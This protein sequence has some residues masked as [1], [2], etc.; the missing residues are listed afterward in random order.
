MPTDYWTRLTQLNQMARGEIES[1]THWLLAPDLSQTAALPVWE[2][3]TVACQDVLNLLPLPDYAVR[4][5][6]G[7]QRGASSWLWHQHFGALQPPN[8]LPSQLPDFAQQF[9]WS[10]AHQITWECAWTF[11]QTTETLQSVT[12][13]LSYAPYSLQKIPLM[14][15]DVTQG[16]LRW[17][18]IPANQTPSGLDDLRWEH[19]DQHGWFSDLFLTFCADWLT[20]YPDALMNRATQR[21]IRR[22][23][24]WIQTWG[25]TRH[26][27][28]WLSP[29]GAVSLGGELGLLALTGLIPSHG[30]ATIALLWSV[31]N[32]AGWYVLNNAIPLRPPHP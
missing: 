29:L 32:L 4:L 17:Q 20:R 9:Y 28:P 8:L 12:L 18:R 23:W 30:L 27:K 26:S 31:A 6:H 21:R 25:L 2:S 14:T 16:P 13:L 11:N 3:W 24:R 10:S 1:A 15:W 5:S 7:T 19:G 22:Q